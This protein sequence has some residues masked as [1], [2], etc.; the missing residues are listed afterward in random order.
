MNDKGKLYKFCFF[1]NVL[2]GKYNEE[3]IETHNAQNLH[4]FAQQYC[5]DNSLQ[6]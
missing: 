5:Y 1:I 2:I 3:V 6:F 4:V